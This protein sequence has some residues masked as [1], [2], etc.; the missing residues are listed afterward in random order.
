[1]AK[2]AKGILVRWAPGSV[3]KVFVAAFAGYDAD[4]AGHELA[5]ESPVVKGVE[6]VVGNEGVVGCW[7]EFVQVYGCC[8]GEET[9]V[10]C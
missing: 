9:V 1:V 4:V 10:G 5:G 7:A 3:E 8:G 2:T 6:E